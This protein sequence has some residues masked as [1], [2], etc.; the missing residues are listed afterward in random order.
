MAYI[1]GSVLNETPEGRP[2][3]IS[4]VQPI[5]PV[6][7]YE[8]A[9]R[10]AESITRDYDR[11]GHDNAV[12]YVITTDRAL[13]NVSE[14]HPELDVM[15]SSR[16]SQM[17]RNCYLKFSPEQWAEKQDHTDM[18]EVGEDKPS[19]YFDIDGTLG[20]WYADGRGYSS[21]E[22]IIDPANHYFRDIEPHPFMIQLAEQLQ[23]EGHDVCIVSAADRNTIRDKMEWIH[24]N[25]PFIKDENVFFSP[26]GADKTQFIKDNA[27]IS[28]LVDDYNVNLEAWKGAAVK[29]INTV[30]SHQDTFREIDMTVPER[31]MQRHGERVLEAERLIEAG[32]LPEY[33]ADEIKS[34]AAESMA[35]QLRRAMET[36]EGELE[37][38]LNME[39]IKETEQ[40]D[41]RNIIRHGKKLGSSVDRSEYIASGT[42]AS[43]TN[44]TAYYQYGEKYYRCSIEN[45]DFA[46]TRDPEANEV[47]Y[48]GIVSELAEAKV[49]AETYEGVYTDV[50]SG[51]TADI[52]SSVMDFH[53]DDAEL[54][55]DVAK[56]IIDK[57]VGSLAEK[58]FDN[59]KKAS[60][61]LNEP[62]VD[63]KYFGEW[64]LETIKVGL[65][66]YETTAM[67]VDALYEIDDKFGTDP[68][69]Y[70]VHSAGELEHSLKENG[71]L[72]Q[73]YERKEAKGM[74]NEAYV[75][76]RHKEFESGDTSD[77]F[78]VR[79]SDGSAVVLILEENGEPA[80][81][82]MF[83]ETLGEAQGEVAD[84]IKEVGHY[85]GNAK[86][87]EAAYGEA[88]Q[89]I[90]ESPEIEP[91]IQDWAKQSLDVAKEMIEKLEQ[92]E[93]DNGFSKT[94]EVESAIGTVSLTAYKMQGLQ[95]DIQSIMDIDGYTTDS[96]AISGG[97]QN[98][99]SYAS[100]IVNAAALQRENELGKIHLQQ[101]YDE[102]IFPLRDVPHS[103][104]TEEQRD[105][106]AMFSDMHKDYYYHRPHSDEQNV[107]YQHHMEVEQKREAA[108]ETDLTSMV[109]DGLEEPMYDRPNP[110]DT[111]D[112]VNFTVP[113]YDEGLQIIADR[114]GLLEAAVDYQTVT[115]VINDDNATINVYLNVDRAEGVN[116]QA[117]LNY[118]APVDVP[119]T[120]EEIDQFL[121][122]A[123]QSLEKEGGIVKF[124]DDSRE[125][126]GYYDA[127]D[128][129][130][131]EP[132][133]GSKSHTIESSKVE[134]LTVEMF[135][136]G[137]GSASLNGNEFVQF[138]LMTGE[139]NFER[140]GWEA[141]GTHSTE[142]LM[143]FA[144]TYA[145]ETL[146]AKEIE[147]PVKWFDEVASAED[148]TNDDDTAKHFTLEVGEDASVVFDTESPYRGA[149][150]FVDV[151]AYVN[152][153]GEIVVDF[154]D[155]GESADEQIKGYT[156]D[157]GM[158][159]TFYDLPEN[160]VDMVKDK[161][162]GLAIEE[163]ALDIIKQEIADNPH[164]YDRY[165]D[166]RDQIEPSTIAEAFH[167]Y[168]AEFEDGGHSDYPDFEAFLA[169][170]IY[171]KWNMDFSD[172]E[173]IEEDFKQNHT[174]SEMAIVQAYLDANDLNIEEVLYENGF[175]GVQFD[176]K[177]V[178]GDYKLNIMLTTPTEQNYDM[179]SIPDMFGVEGAEGLDKLLSRMNADEQTQHFD[180][181]LTYLVYQQ[182]H[183]LTE[184]TEA[185]YSDTPSDNQ[186]VKSVVDELNDFPQ[187]SMAEL[188]VLVQ[189]N[190][191]GLETLDMIAKGEGDITF[192]KETTIGLYNE[193][194][195]AGSMLDIQ[196]EQDFTVP[197][198]MVRNVQIEGQK[199]D[200]THGYTVDSTYGLVG[201]CWKDTMSKA[202]E[203]AKGVEIT[204][205]YQADLPKVVDT[206]KEAAKPEQDK[207]KKATDDFGNR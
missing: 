172:M 150:I 62:P 151:T 124:I 125:A 165:F 136:D 95:R 115:D 88:L 133:F 59:L 21:I 92:A 23:R 179:G 127:P 64:D 19:V 65:Q 203:P 69:Y 188:T 84:C 51:S 141:W 183:D 116:M 94:I 169:Q 89:I 185:F 197:A 47:S 189:L 199:S 43:H 52:A 195:G 140:K 100:D 108:M 13:Q 58:I 202:E 159:E 90:A 49:V 17:L 207:A 130:D 117:T 97:G 75:V 173:I 160:V 22:E 144:E 11:L 107:C 30:N 143:H 186:F 156:V 178:V 10:L 162:M 57:E 139:T 91:E 5:E 164:G 29:A 129:P 145:T 177:E 35:H 142:A 82:H 167:E 26:I 55:N 56:H 9:L 99:Y 161:A 8:D 1:V 102:E 40:P 76:P 39:E 138:D 80:T 181:A 31:M 104:L 24:E 71:Y 126:T 63:G 16:D 190:K 135:E 87:A 45:D 79:T 146:G 32:E 171:E 187:Y 14:Q 37:R 20:K 122:L 137:S 96:D 153:D 175:E 176:V 182:G 68:M 123:Q 192:S 70:G 113:M 73:S 38:I 191:E 2:H 204:K 72:E 44:E 42:V 50:Y 103:E 85:Y 121:T 196:L 157:A 61:E 7:S 170:K 48:D 15:W 180:N 60:E 112:C 77:G 114:T 105:N 86:H 25:M 41:A 168:Q 36:V 166:Y 131:E 119:L 83:V 3:E 110:N 66:A 120:G 53:I 67:L 106:M 174:E 28:V 198:D 118:D 78:T 27:E 134:G 46:D 81:P 147:D 163:I 34:Q 200:Y 128:L 205:A 193:W 93:S 111:H 155:K 194:Q 132:P 184:L 101:F 152:S 33:A 109:I 158:H 148:H 6:E 54:A 18:F 74:E 206:V 201:S 98:I 149:S 154:D 12:E 4:V